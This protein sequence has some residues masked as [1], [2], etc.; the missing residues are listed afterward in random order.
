[1]PRG[2]SN[3][4]T[5][6]RVQRQ[7]GGYAAINGLPQREFEGVPLTKMR[8]KPKVSHSPSAIMTGQAYCGVLLPAKP[9]PTRLA[10]VV[11]FDSVFGASCQILRSDQALGIWAS[12]VSKETELGLSFP[13]DVLGSPR[14]KGEFANSPH[15]RPNRRHHWPSRSR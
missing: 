15:R 14:S 8:V 1:M 9:Y 12:Q 3:E 10:L 4:P 7:P 2:L 11:V 13:R 5:A 6:Y